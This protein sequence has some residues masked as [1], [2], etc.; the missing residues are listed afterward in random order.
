MS[1]PTPTAD[2]SEPQSSSTSQSPKRS[3]R[4]PWQAV[5][6]ATVL[7]LTAAGLV[8]V[9][10]GGD[11]GNDDLR[12]GNSL[13]LTPADGVDRAG[14]VD[15]EFTDPD[16]DAGT[17]RGLLD[18]RPMVVNFFA[19]WCP[20]C[21]AEMPEFEDV[22]QDLAGTVDFVGLAV[23]DRPEDA[24][25]IVDTTGITYPW[26]RDVRGDIAGAVGVVQMPT[27]MLIDADGNV[28]AVHAGALDA[29][30]LREFVEDNVS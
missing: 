5:V 25:R 8:L 9:F 12:T 29:D 4:L 19:S 30:G 27:T 20:P 6:A 23:Q 2:P 7:A 13:Q 22:S 11:D 21:I 14:A 26:A 24:S 28:V 10:L 15:V 16:G 1:A 17:L 3:A 18:G